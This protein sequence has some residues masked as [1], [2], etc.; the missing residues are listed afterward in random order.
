MSLTGPLF[1]DGIVLLTVLAFVGLVLIWP[2]LT[3][4]TPWHIAGRAGALALL[5]AL[6]LL[7][8]ITQLNAAYLFFASWSDLQG[9]ISGH[10]SQTALDRGGAATQAPNIA[11][12][13]PAA[14][15]AAQVPPL[16]QQVGSDGL[17]RYTV[18]GAMSGLTG[19]VL[20][21]PPSGYTSPAQATL[22]YPVIEAF[23]GYPSTPLSWVKRFNIR[24]A[25]YGQ[26][27][28]HKIHPLFVVMPQIEFPAGVDTEG[29]NAGPGTPQVETWLT[30]DV[31]DWVAQHFRVQQNRNAW[32]TMG[33]SAGGFDAAMAT[34]LHPAQ[35][36]AGIV[37][38][39]YFRPDFGPLYEP[40]LPK[41]PLGRRYDLIRVAA[42]HPPPVALWM[43]TSHADPVSYGSS[44]RFLKVAGPPTAVHA[45]ILRNAGHRDSVWVALLPQAL[46][47]LGTNVQGF[48]PGP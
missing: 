8:A 19:T 44:A 26:A 20:V 45:V 31:P 46:T 34:T 9:A 47:W 12:S 35:Y 28:I 5:N 32:A 2:R 41:S 29:V 43:E 24:Q 40:F 39:G 10:I 3:P 11:V 22:R 25:I 18:H 33:D 37:L 21:L 48:H 16:T 13:G 17:L 6:V 1:L 30:R 27:A 4:R 7:T 23:H 14:S 36:G 15:V 38:G 42:H